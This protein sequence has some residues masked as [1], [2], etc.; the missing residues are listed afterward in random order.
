MVYNKTLKH[1]PPNSSWFYINKKGWIKIIL[2]SFIVQR[3][4]GNSTLVLVWPSHLYSRPNPRAPHPPSTSTYAT[5]AYEPYVRTPRG[6]F[7]RSEVAT[8]ANV[9]LMLVSYVRN[10]ASDHSVRQRHIR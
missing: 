9:A 1:S 5:N 8:N 4:T 10:K 6:W 2:S 3:K 7:F